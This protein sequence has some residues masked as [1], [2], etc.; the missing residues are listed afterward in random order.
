MADRGK[1]LIIE[2]V[3]LSGVLLKDL[4]NPDILKAVGK[5]NIPALLLFINM[6]NKKLTII[7]HQKPEEIKEKV[8]HV[9]S[10]DQE[11]VKKLSKILEKS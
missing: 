4:I 5:E 11:I 10:Q 3:K 6:K 9:E 7:S 1:N 8:I 2:K